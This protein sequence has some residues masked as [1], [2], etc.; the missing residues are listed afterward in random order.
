VSVFPAV[1]GDDPPGVEEGV[2]LP[3]APVGVAVDGTVGVE[4]VGPD[5]VTVARLSVGSGKT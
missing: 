3:D 1:P 4:I 5:G 2:G